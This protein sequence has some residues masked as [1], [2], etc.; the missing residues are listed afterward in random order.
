MQTF[1]EG[2][3]QKR[4]IYHDFL[5]TVVACEGSRNRYKDIGELMKRCE[6]LVATRDNLLETRDKIRSA[7]QKEEESLA[8]FKEEQNA[9]I[10]DLR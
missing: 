10:L 3:A 9:R 2:V 4:K 6:T 7:I 8:Q 1:L 5:Q